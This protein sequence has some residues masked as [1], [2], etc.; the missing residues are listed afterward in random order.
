MVKE[1]DNNSRYFH[2][3]ASTK[4]RRNLILRLNVNRHVVSSLNRIK[5]EIRCYFKR[6]YNQEEVPVLNFDGG[7]VHS[8]SIEEAASWKYFHLRRRLR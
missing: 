6:L 8:I 2:A 3:I 5:K 7:L 4:R 1:M